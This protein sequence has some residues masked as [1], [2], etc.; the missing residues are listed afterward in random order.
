[1]SVITP[2]GISGT[3]SIVPGANSAPA[4]TPVKPTIQTPPSPTV[5]GAQTTANATTAAN[6]TNAGK[7]G[8]DVFGN[9]TGTG[10][11]DIQQARTSG[12]TYTGVDGQTYYNYD[13]TPTSAAPPNAPTTSSTSSTG[14][15]TDSSGTSTGTST[16]TSDVNQQN[17]A[18]E[19]AQ[20]AQADADYQAQAKQVSDT[21]TNIQNGTTPLT[22]GEQA[23]I[24]GLKAQF[25]TFIDAQT[26]QNAGASGTANV[27]GYQTGAAEYDPTFQVK[28]IGA[29]I[30]AGQQKI[31]TLD[32]QMASAVASLTQSFHDNDIKAV[33]D[34]W[35]IYQ[36]A[37]KEHADAIQKTIDDTQ[38]AIKNAQD[39]AQAS[40][41]EADKQQEDKY[42]QVTKPINDIAT[43]AAKNG[44]DAK[45]IAAIN[46]ATDV[47]SAINAA[48]DSLQTATGQLGDYLQY[49]K[50]ATQNGKVPED[51]STWKAADDAQTSKEKAS[52]AYA[53]AF[54]TASGKADADAKNQQQLPQSPVTSP[55]GLVYN[56]P[57]SIAPYVNFAANG[58]KYVDM[59]HF[60]GTPTEKNQA[61]QDAQQ[62]GYKVI[63]N[64]NTA[65]DVQNIT[66]ATSK[67]ADIKAAFAKASAG[68]ATQRNLYAAA[69]NTVA[70]KLQTNPNYAGIDVYQDAALDILKAL[71][72]VQGFRGGASMVQQVKD[73]FPSIT[74]TTAYNNA[75]IDNLQKLI[76]D[77]QTALV[78]NPSA[79]DK[80]L[81]DEQNNEN[82][83]T[84]NLQ[85]MKTSNP[86]IYQAASS[87]YTSINPST[88]QPYTAADILQAFPE[89]NQ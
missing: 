30:S 81:I 60:G 57:A 35:S 33:T 76:D 80:L 39:Q 77:R 8:Y 26:L 78:G 61:I 65:L 75:K 82:N 68:D 64:A 14:T 37:A 49:K 73:T 41:A 46:A 71:S 9:P 51:Y 24:D 58:V 66:D 12:G 55:S 54:A 22:T 45:T 47:T 83:L 10:G 69:F 67:L 59:S 23:Q 86:K 88:N 52:E 5:P 89:L 44:A 25:Q 2:T 1:M 34:A 11:A 38:A 87:M 84:T 7:P 21:I 32:T 62:A 17:L 40:Q 72:G 15:A 36:D 70:D 31:A 50:D 18:Q 79:S 56:A 6:Q 29:V 19:Q 48:G 85:S 74:N 13:H 20:R 43:E 53:T 28:T 16:D 27:R 63:T 42:S 4:G 3:G